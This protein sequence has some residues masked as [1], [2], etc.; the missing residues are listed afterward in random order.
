MTEQYFKWHSPYLGHGF[1][2]LVFG[3]RGMPVVLFP[4][5][6]GSYTE[7]RDRGM[8]EA[9]HWFVQQG[10]IR[11]YCPDS[12]NGES[13]Y[14][15]GVAPSVRVLNHTRYEETILREVVDRARQETG[16]DRVVMA[17]CSFGGYHAANF[18]FRHPE[19]VR[20]L[21]TMSGLFDISFRLDGYYDDSVYF[22]NPVDYMGDNEDPGL[23]EMGIVLGAAET[24]I[25]R[26]D[27]ERF[28]GLLTTKGIPHWLDIQP[29]TTHDWPTWRE[30]FPRYLARIAS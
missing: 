3:E 17:G 19:M 14:N 2:M 6:M 20:Y 16:Y 4:T 29:G 11:I 26:G 22:N 18:S 9:A 10:L 1:Q 28:S 5:S 23:W 21:F 7:Y 25:C 30:M 27:N 12:I 13:W 8:V 15:A 24:D